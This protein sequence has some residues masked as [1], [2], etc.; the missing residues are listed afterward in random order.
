MTAHVCTGRQSKQPLHYLTLESLSHPSKKRNPQPLKMPIPTIL[1][2][3][4]FRWTILRRPIRPRSPKT[5]PGLK[6]LIT[7]RVA[8]GKRKPR[9][10]LLLSHGHVGF[11]CL[12]G[13][14]SHRRQRTASRL[15]FSLRHLMVL[16]LLPILHF[17]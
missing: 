4:Y 5:T 7:L 14:R 3:W 8:G 10:E 11:S 17:R 15:F 9:E 2:H 13:R 6:S 12:N 16:H 1:C